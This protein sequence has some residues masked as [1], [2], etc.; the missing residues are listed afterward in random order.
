VQGVRRFLSISLGDACSVRR[1]S[2][3]IVIVAFAFAATLA[4]PVSSATCDPRLLSCAPDRGWAK[5]LEEEIG[6]HIWDGQVY[7]LDY[8]VVEGVVTDDVTRVTHYGDSALWTGTYLAAESFRYALSKS[9]LARPLLPPDERNFWAHSKAQA[10]ARIADIVRKYEI[11]VNISREWNHEFAPSLEQPGFGGGVIAGEPGY[12][13][14][15][16]HDINAPEYTRWSNAELGLKADGSRTA[17]APPAPYTK[18]RRVFGPFPW[19]NADG[20]VTQYYCEDGTSRDAYAGVTF[21]LQTAFDLVGPDD[22][23]LRGR[24]ATDLVTLGNFAF[25][26]AWNT[27]RPH[28]RISLPLDEAEPIT[29]MNCDDFNAQYPPACGHDFENFISPLFV[30]TPMARMNMTLGAAHVAPAIP[31]PVIAAAE[32]AKWQAILAEEMA[33]QGPVLAFSME[34]D[35]A[36]PYNSYYKHNLSHLIG[37]NLGMRAPTPAHKVIYKQAVGAMDNTTGDDINA[38][39]EAITYALTGEMSRREAAIKHLR[40]WREYRTNIESVGVVNNSQFC[41]TTLECVP[42]SQLEITTAAG[43][44]PIIVEGSGG[45]RSRFPLPVAQ[46]APSDFIWQRE[47]NKLD[48]S[49]ALNHRAPGIDYLLPYWMIRYHTEI[50]VP[51]LEPFPIWPGNSYN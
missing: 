29:G 17:D 10:K 36:D 12:L 14:R 49:E 35:S 30:I 46:R 50:K 15:A 31:D 33:T 21:G 7:E 43:G 9:Y 41:G 19:T 26:Y 25:K 1:R 11:L 38:H 3:P 45:L 39:F 28:G 37:Y 44:D 47:P 42:K 34:F 13:M 32:T 27:P 16:C 8:K 5:D 4:P 22:A 18:K 24:I 48:G 6:R 51:A 40:E 2:L 23:K 20:S